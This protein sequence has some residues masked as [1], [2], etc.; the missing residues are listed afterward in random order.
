M[1]EPIEPKKYLSY[2]IVPGERLMD[3]TQSGWELVEI[4]HQTR[5]EIGVEQVPL[6]NP[7]GYPTSMQGQRSHVVSYTQ[8]LLGQT[9]LSESI[10]FLSDTKY[11]AER[12][13]AA[14][15]GKVRELTEEMKRSK[16]SYDR[17]MKEEMERTERAEKQWTSWE[18]KTKEQ[19]A[20]SQRMENDLGKVRKA[21]G[22]L[23]M[24]EIIEG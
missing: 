14:A 6:S 20:I 23:R 7:G 18:A 16:L 12:D 4:L 9:P 19:Q 2:C 10:R 8:F 21:L 1:T 5:V 22:D 11:Q 24:K 15:N 17:D 13:L 3:L